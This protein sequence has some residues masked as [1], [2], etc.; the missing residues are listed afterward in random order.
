MADIVMV[1][2][3]EEASVVTHSGKF[4]AGNVFTAILISQFVPEVRIFRTDNLPK[5]ANHPR[6]LCYDLPGT[7]LEKGK[8]ARENGIKYGCFG[9]MWKTTGPL[10]V[11]LLLEAL[12]K[13]E[14]KEFDVEVICNT[15][16]KTFIQSIDAL[17]NGQRDLLDKDD[18]VFEIEKRVDVFN[19]SEKHYENMA[20]MTGWNPE[21]DHNT[22]LDECFS[23]ACEL[24]EPLFKK[25]LLLCINLVKE[26]KKAFNE[27]FLEMLEKDPEG[28][29]EMIKNSLKKE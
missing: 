10:L 20:K 15:F 24:L 9:L 7:K 22:I 25:V 26:E 13:H 4:T 3:L 2:T 8:L 6:F 27:A 19:L 21:W 28:T 5:K 11:S 1:N 12:D 14:D 17:D 23:Q 29:L 16:D 18:P